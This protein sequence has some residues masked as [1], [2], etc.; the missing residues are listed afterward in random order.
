MD[1]LPEGISAKEKMHIKHFNEEVLYA[2]GSVIKVEHSDIVRFKKRAVAT[3]RKR[4]RL[5]THR[6]VDDKVH[7]MLIVHTKGTYIKPHKHLNKTESFHIIE[8]SADIIIFDD[9]GRLTEVVEMGDYSSGLKFYYRISEPF[10]HT[11]LIKSDFIV[12]HETTN[13]PF[14]KSDT[15]FAPWAPECNDGAEVEG[16]LKKLSGVVKQ[17]KK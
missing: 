10:F 16:Y 1:A 2:E 15:M 13:G 9:Y 11:L 17:F 4:I 12:F 3:Q 6:N 5:C 14:I 7:E 8:G